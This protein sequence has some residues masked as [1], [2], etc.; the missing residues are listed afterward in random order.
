VPDVTDR[1]EF[2]AQ[3][4][5]IQ[6]VK[7]LEPLFSVKIDGELIRQVLSNLIENAIKYSPENST[8]KVRTKEGHGKIKVSVV[9]E[10]PGIPPEELD[11]VFLKF[12][13]SKQVKTS[14]IKGTGLGLYL[15]KYFVELHGGSLKAES[16]IQKGSRFTVEIP[17]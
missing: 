6:I 10:G 8:I 11:N 17:F 12:Y 1:Y 2:L 14:A 3:S 16:Q 7:E 15:A 4:K 13:R 9:D 5:N